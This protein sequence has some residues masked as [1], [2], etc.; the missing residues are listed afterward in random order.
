ML[1]FWEEEAIRW[2]LLEQEQAELV[3]AMAAEGVAE[4]LKKELKI[5]LEGV[6]MRKGMRPSQRPTAQGE[7]PSAQQPEAVGPPQYA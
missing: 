2:R 5:R 1:F 3:T 4:E 7:N 6:Q